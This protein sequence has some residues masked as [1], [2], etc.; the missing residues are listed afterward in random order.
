MK[1]LHFFKVLTLNHGMIFQQYDTDC[2][3]LVQDKLRC[4]VCSK[5]RANL[6]VVRGR[7]QKESNKSQFT[8]DRYLSKDEL[9]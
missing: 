7:I 3:L 2:F 5:Y 1:I 4:D 9:L 8:N 6:N